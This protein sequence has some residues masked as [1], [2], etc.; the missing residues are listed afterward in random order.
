MMYFKQ[1][2]IFALFIFTCFNSFSQGEKKYSSKEEHAYYES[3]SKSFTYK[4]YVPVSVEKAMS[5]PY[6]YVKISKVQHPVIYNPE[7]DDSKVIDSM[8][9][10]SLNLKVDIFNKVSVLKH[11]K[12]GDNWAIIYYDA[13]YDDFVD[14]RFGYWLALSRDNGKT[15]K[16]YYTG[17]SENFYFH[18]KW[19]SKLPLWKNAEI[20]QIESVILRQDSEGGHPFPPTFCPNPL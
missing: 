1:A 3:R 19:D 10:A 8:R 14:Y 12:L 7:R 6:G 13:K 16:Q 20:L 2:F 4:D 11:E 18:F 17:L 15:W 5:N 9:S